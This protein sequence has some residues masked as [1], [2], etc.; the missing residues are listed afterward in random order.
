MSEVKLLVKHQCL[1]ER[2]DH[3]FLVD[4]KT[5][6]GKKLYCPYC[7]GNTLSAAQQSPDE[8]IEEQLDGCLHPQ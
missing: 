4:V 1:D 8:N 5:A 2:C 7:K 3:S 6:L